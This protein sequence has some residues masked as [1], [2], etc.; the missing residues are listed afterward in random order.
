MGLFNF[1]KCK[2]KNKVLIGYSYSFYTGLFCTKTYRHTYCPRCKKTFTDEIGNHI[3]ESKAKQD[4]FIEKI[5]DK[6]FL[7]HGDMQLKIDKYV[8]G[9]E[10]VEIDILDDL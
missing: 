8:Y 4:E 5:K 1:F 2:C 9:K 10:L 6:G 3:S 7:W